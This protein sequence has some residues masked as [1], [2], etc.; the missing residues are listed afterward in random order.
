MSK[1]TLTK[2][3]LKTLAKFIVEE[4]KKY[5]E[6]DTIK[7]LEKQF[8]K[9]KEKLKKIL[10]D[11]DSKNNFLEEFITD[12]MEQQEEFI[13]IDYMPDMNKALFGIIEDLE[14]IVNDMN[15]EAKQYTKKLYEKYSYIINQKL[16][17]K[18]F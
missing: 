15:K 3:D 2:T 9:K 6:Q 10:K 5:D 4:T 8:E 16:V 18:G 1:S 12:I 14:D 7:K 11:E 13:D 17:D